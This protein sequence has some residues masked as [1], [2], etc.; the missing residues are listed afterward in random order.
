MQ[1]RFPAGLLLTSADTELG[2][3][4]ARETCA[5]CRR[6]VPSVSQSAINQ[7]RITGLFFLHAWLALPT[8]SEAGMIKDGWQAGFS[9]GEHTAHWQKKKK[10]HNDTRSVIEWRNDFMTFDEES[11]SFK[12]QIRRV[13]TRTCT[14]SRNPN[15]LLRRSAKTY[16]KASIIQLLVLLLECLYL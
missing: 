9:G 3:P 1:T 14:L 10:N 15:A 8:W 16:H 13:Q 7:N 2:W 6:R 5:L 11:Y 4:D 12:T